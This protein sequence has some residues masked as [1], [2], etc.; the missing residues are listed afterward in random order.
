MISI[1]IKE[2]RNCGAVYY[3]GDTLVIEKYE[4][5]YTFKS[6]VNSCFLCPEDFKRKIK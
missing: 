6:K 3:D 2:C 1:P 4:E 5:I